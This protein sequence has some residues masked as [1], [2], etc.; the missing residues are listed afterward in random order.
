MSTLFFIEN[1]C[2]KYHFKMVDVMVY[3]YSSF[4]IYFDV[5]MD[6]I[7]IKNMLSGKLTSINLQKC[8]SNGVIDFVEHLD[9]IHRKI[10]IQQIEK[11]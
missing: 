7:E 8:I 6:D 4:L 3:H 2:E 11:L 9:Y 1:L 10:Y 5:A